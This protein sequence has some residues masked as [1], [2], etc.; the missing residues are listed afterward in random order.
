MALYA[1]IESV[2]MGRDW[3]DRGV[4]LRNLGV[5]WGWHRKWR[6]GFRKSSPGSVFPV[7]PRDP[8]GDTMK[9]GN[10]RRPSH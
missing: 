4:S 7:Q 8:S 5:S 9:F 3:T 2:A 1:N 10:V 6:E